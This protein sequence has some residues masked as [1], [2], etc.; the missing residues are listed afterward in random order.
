MLQLQWEMESIAAV[1]SVDITAV[2]G[3]GDSRR[4]ILASPIPCAGESGLTEVVVVRKLPDDVELQYAIDTSLVK[5]AALL[6]LVA[7]FRFLYAI[8]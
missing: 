2:T 5:M 8:D 1:H 3:R 4:L 7:R 6:K